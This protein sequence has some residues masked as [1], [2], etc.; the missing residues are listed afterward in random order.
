[1]QISK[2]VKLTRPDIFAS[3][4][5]QDCSGEDE[6]GCTWSRCK[7]SWNSMKTT[8]NSVDVCFEVMQLHVYLTSVSPC[9]TISVIF[10]FH[11]LSGVIH[12]RRSRNSPFQCCGPL[13]S[14]PPF[15]VSIIFKARVWDSH[16]IVWR[17]HVCQ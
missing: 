14:Y 5:V 12:V 9:F 3:D 4:Y 13:D 2:L 15:T 1:V 7:D 8:E 17:N 10:W 16:G 11:R 6:I